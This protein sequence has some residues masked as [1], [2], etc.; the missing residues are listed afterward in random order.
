MKIEQSGRDGD[1]L[2]GSLQFS[3]EQR[4]AVSDIE[5]RGVEMGIRIG[6][7]FYS[8]QL[9]EPAQHW[10]AVEFLP[11][12]LV[13]VVLQT[14]AAGESAAS[15]AVQRAARGLEQVAHRMPVH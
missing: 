7:L 3:E 11:D 13:V 14:H 5:W 8:E 15:A 4:S 1:K 10:L 2:A 6:R 12:A 9:L